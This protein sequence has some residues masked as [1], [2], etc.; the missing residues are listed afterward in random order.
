LRTAKGD[1]SRPQT[2]A[3]A[4]LAFCYRTPGVKYF[5]DPK[6]LEL[7]K[8]GYVAAAKHVEPDGR[9]HW[10]GDVGYWYEAHEQAWRL[11]AFLIGYVWAGE[12]FSPDEKK[13]VEA[14]LLRAAEWQIANPLLQTQQPRHGLLRRRPALRVV[15]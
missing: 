2:N 1:L 9:F 6:A 14:A 15:L 11:E 10:A 3:L 7:L 12:H 13:V 8:R 5:H 4:R